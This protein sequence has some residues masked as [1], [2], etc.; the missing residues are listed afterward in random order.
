MRGQELLFV[1]TVSANNGCKMTKSNIHSGFSFLKHKT[2]YGL[3]AVVASISLCSA[4]AMADDKGLTAADIP[5]LQSAYYIQDMESDL[6]RYET[7]M[8]VISNTKNRDEFLINRDELWASR[9]ELSFAIKA[10]EGFLNSPYINDV[11]Q[12]TDILNDVLI[13][14]EEYAN[15][16]N[17][18]IAMKSKIDDGVASLH[19][20]FSDIKHAENL[21]HH[22]HLSDEQMEVVNQITDARSV[23][24]T[25]M[26]SYFEVESSKDMTTFTQQL[27]NS[28]NAY[29]TIVDNALPAYPELNESYQ[30]L[31]KYYDGMF[32]DRGAGSR[33]FEYLQQHE[34]QTEVKE[35]FFRVVHDTFKKVDKLNSKV[36]QQLKM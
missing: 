36:K 1:N 19:S 4:T 25:M 7:A 23:L 22:R 20:I 18:L 28:Y 34:K 32:K 15:L 2:A 26:T 33:Y 8:M 21:I 12:I 31:K 11:K 29:A 17:E 3:L 16:Q 5:A 9:E 24:E 14:C 13:K 6:H 30:K 27:Q 10:N 35:Y